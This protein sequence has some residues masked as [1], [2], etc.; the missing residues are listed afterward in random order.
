MAAPWGIYHET[1]E[2]HQENPRGSALIVPVKTSIILLLTSIWNRPIVNTED[3]SHLDLATWPEDSNFTK[4]LCLSTSM[5]IWLPS[6]SKKM[7]SALHSCFLFKQPLI[8]LRL[9]KMTAPHY[10]QVVVIGTN[11][12]T[13]SRL[14]SLNLVRS[15]ITEKWCGSET[16]KQ[17]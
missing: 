14:L 9:I 15:G 5:I 16:K 17:N 3:R 7:N 1:L 2:K 8:H 4:C 11:Y 13:P 10:D 6:S 12:A